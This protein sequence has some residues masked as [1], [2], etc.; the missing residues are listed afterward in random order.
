MKSETISIRLNKPEQTVSLPFL[1]TTAKPDM[2]RPNHYTRS[3]Q[4]MTDPHIIRVFNENGGFAVIT[5][6]SSAT[7]AERTF[8]VEG[9]QEQTYEEMSSNGKILRM[10]Y[11]LK[12]DGKICS[13]QVTTEEEGGE[14][15]I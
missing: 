11:S 4:V 10:I 14:Q 12:T 13:L 9:W 2:T 15:W 6:A 1:F 7:H 8:L 3:G 5:P